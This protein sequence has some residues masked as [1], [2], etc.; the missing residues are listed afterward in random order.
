M[1][2]HKICLEN[3]VAGMQHIGLPVR[4][5]D[6]TVAFY[7]KLG[8]AILWQTELNGAPV[9]FLRGMGITVE[10][11]LS[12]DATGGAGALD[13]IA[14]SVGD[15]DRAWDDISKLG[16]IPDGESIH[17]LPFFDRGVKYFTIV[18]PNAEKIEFNQIL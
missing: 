6:T 15:I 16:L 9:C 3:N 12:G 10:A 17:T 2:T 4:D 13:H 11:Y 14:L 1:Y 18:G 8:F 5:M 7:Q